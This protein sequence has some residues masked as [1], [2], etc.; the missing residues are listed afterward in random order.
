MAWRTEQA[1]QP[2]E[3]SGSAPR[4]APR[5]ARS[6]RSSRGSSASAPRATR[7]AAVPFDKSLP[8]SGSPGLHSYSKAIPTS[9]PGVQAGAIAS[10]ILPT[11]HGRSAALP[12]RHPPGFRLAAPA[13]RSPHASRWPDFIVGLPG[14]P[15]RRPGRWAH[16]RP[17]GGTGVLSYPYDFDQLVLV[18]LPPT[19]DTARPLESVGAATPV[20]AS[21]LR[22]PIHGQLRL[23][24]MASSTSSQRPVHRARDRGR[25]RPGAEGVLSDPHA[26]RVHGHRHSERS[27]LP[28]QQDSFID[29]DH[30]VEYTLGQ[31]RHKVPA[32]RFRRAHRAGVEL[33]RPGCCPGRFDPVALAAITASTTT[34]RRATYWR[35]CCR[36]P[37]DRAAV[38]IGDPM[39]V[40]RS[41]GCRFEDEHRDLPIGPRLVV[42]VVGIGGDR[43]GPPQRLLLAAQLAGHHL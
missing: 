7:L 2:A 16:H 41:P 5:S 26:R 29:P 15:H 12:Q 22:I 37:A 23:P 35:C 30:E 40:P 34:P 42:G 3:V 31:L 43:P 13:S 27:G 33:G 18:D 9:R 39:R 11:G 28:T 4:S 20:C 19:T 25:R 21:P 10:G 24:V 38:R 32:G 36:S 17:A 8:G 1:L 14:P 6:P